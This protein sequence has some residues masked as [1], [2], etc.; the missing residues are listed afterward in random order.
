MSLN[1]GHISWIWKSNRFLFISLQKIWS[2]IYLF[3][4]FIETI[5]F[6][7]KSS[8]S[9]SI[10][11]KI[12]YAFI[13]YGLKVFIKKKLSGILFCCLRSIFTKGNFLLWGSRLFF[14]SWHFCIK[15]KDNL[16][17]FG[18]FKSF[19]CNTKFL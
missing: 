7:E 2:K 16:L 5:S 18:L 15:V 3:F 8:R 9:S 14:K 4:Y 1:F 6:R 17:F 12:F 13:L 11:Y 10:F 19:L